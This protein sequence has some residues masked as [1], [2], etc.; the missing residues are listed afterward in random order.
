MTE[1]SSPTGLSRTWKKTKPF[2]LNYIKHALWFKI[3]I[4]SKETKTKRD[5]KKSSFDRVCVIFDDI[6]KYETV[7][8]FFI[9]LNK[10]N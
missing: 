5:T 4:H 6:I 9:N 10:L 3:F 2:R 8:G 7:T 1:G